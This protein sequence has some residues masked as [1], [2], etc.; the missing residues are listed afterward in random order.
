[1]I[2]FEILRNDVRVAAAQ[3]DAALNA[4]MRLLTHDSQASRQA[5]WYREYAFRSLPAPA[6]GG[7]S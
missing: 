6:A 1:M 7:Q 4:A 3:D 2:R 5:Y